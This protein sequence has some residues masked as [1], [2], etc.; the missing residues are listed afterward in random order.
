MKRFV[1]TGLL[2][3]G[4][5][6]GMAVA[7]AQD[8]GA[9]RGFDPDQMRERMMDRMKTELKASDEEWTVIQGLLQDVM[10][11]QRELTA[12]RVGGMAAFAGQRGRPDAPGQGPQQGARGGRPAGAQGA[13]AQGAA[14]AELEKLSSALESPN[15]T[16]TQLKQHLA[17]VRAAREKAEA[18]L[19]KARNDLR[20]V[21]TVEQEAK[22]VVMG[23][24][25]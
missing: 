22:L 13:I 24:M 11:K 19:K 17:A 16:A 20:E 12:G 21:L 5:G 6:A 23:V 2:M 25:D 15:T 8:A 7:T 4:L 18:E 14:A 1:L 10:L 3:V 9:R